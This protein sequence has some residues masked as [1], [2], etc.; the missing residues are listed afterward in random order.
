MTY[1]AIRVL[2]LIGLVWASSAGGAEVC[3]THGRMTR[4]IAEVRAAGTSEAEARATLIP[5]QAPPAIRTL[6]ESTLALVYAS[7]Q[8]PEALA[9]QAE[10]LCRQVFPAGP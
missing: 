1:R 3:A 9:A 2:L 4:A 10:A 5:T 7:N 8:P 6:L